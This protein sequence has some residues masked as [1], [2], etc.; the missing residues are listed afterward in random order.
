M[1]LV[2]APDFEVSEANR[3][4]PL[5]LGRAA[6]SPHLQVWVSASELGSKASPLWQFSF[7]TRAFSPR[8]RR[9]TW[10]GLQPGSPCGF[11]SLDPTFLA[12]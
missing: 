12:L 9:G 8:P 7:L 10:S 11:S 6:G 2:K 5:P 4:K 1:D 3:W